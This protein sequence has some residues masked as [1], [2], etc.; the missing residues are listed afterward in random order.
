MI[1]SFKINCYPLNRSIRI[2]IS[3]PKNYNNSTRFYP[4]IY[5]L[6]GQNVFIDKDSYT[7]ACLDLP[8]TIEK[9]ETESK[10]AIYIGIAAAINETKRNIEYAEDVLAKFIE[11]EIH[12]YLMNRYRMNK[13]IYSFGCSKASKTA[14]KLGFSQ[15]FKGAILFSPVGNFDEITLP[16]DQKLLYLYAGKNEL[17]GLCLDNLTKIAMQYKPTEQ[18]VDENEIHSE[19]GWKK[20]LYSA[21]SHLIL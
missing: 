11:E 12:P 7:G 13:Y 5:F 6:D 10:E 18:L 2:T 8:L 19:D 21:I 20:H 16:K 4:V 14:L 15:L 9:L 17:N 1:E 3:L